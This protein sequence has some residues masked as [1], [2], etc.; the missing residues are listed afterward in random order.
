LFI[1]V[2]AS[3]WMLLLGMEIWHVGQNVMFVF[4]RQEYFM[5]EGSWPLVHPLWIW[6]GWMGGS[7]VHHTGS[8]T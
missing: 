7:L 8:T 1:V 2:A 6:G 4:W 5:Y 3:F